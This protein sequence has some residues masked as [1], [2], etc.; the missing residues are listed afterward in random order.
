MFCFREI[1]Y[2]DGK[3]PLE[4]EYFKEKAKKMNRKSNRCMP[5]GIV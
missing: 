1:F 2:K 3:Y 5:T 4:C